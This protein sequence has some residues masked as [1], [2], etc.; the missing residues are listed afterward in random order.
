MYDFGLRFRRE[1]ELEGHGSLLIKVMTHDAHA[2]RTIQH[3]VSDVAKQ[4][5]TAVFD[6]MIFY[7]SY[8]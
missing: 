2:T 5:P 3:T 4:Y 1:G 8:G 6:G 7:Y